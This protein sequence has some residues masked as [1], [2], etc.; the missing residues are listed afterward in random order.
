MQAAIISDTK[1]KIDFAFDL[2]RERTAEIS[3][4]RKEKGYEAYTSKEYEVAVRLQMEQ[5]AEIGQHMAKLELKEVIRFYKKLNAD[6][7]KSQEY[8]RQ[9]LLSFS[10]KKKELREAIAQAGKTRSSAKTESL[11]GDLEKAKAEYDHLAKLAELSSTV[12]DIE[13]EKIEDMLE[14]NMKREM[15]LERAKKLESELSAYDPEENEAVNSFAIKRIREIIHK[16]KIENFKKEF[17]TLDTNL[18]NLLKDSKKRLEEFEKKAKPPEEKELN[19]KQAEERAAKRTAAQPAKQAK[20]QAQPKPQPVKQP[21]PRP[22]GRP[23]VS[24][25]AG[26]I[27]FLTLGFATEFAGTVGESFEFSFCT[28]PTTRTSDLCTASAT[29]PSGGQ[30]PYHFQLESGVGFPPFGIM[31]YPNG[32]MKGTLRAEGTRAF[33]VCAV[34]LAGLSACRKINFHVVPKVGVAPGSGGTQSEGKSC[35]IQI[36]EC[37]LNNDAE[38]ST[39]YSGCGDEAQCISSC[40][41]KHLKQF[42]VCYALCQ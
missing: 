41:D 23:D 40:N 15:V 21:P 29:D 37:F 18:A 35:A 10:V 2:L 22:L 38:R 13:V 42:Y 39:C 24:K 33:S 26:P 12:T 16:L 28:P 20:E 3:A 25:G 8:L 34:D 7:P 31:L 32:L 19:R 30:P 6:A 36:Q 17:E 14:D 1:K 5:V 27:E 4:I 11:L 9:D